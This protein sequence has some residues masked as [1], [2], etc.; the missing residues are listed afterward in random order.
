MNMEARVLPA[1]SVVKLMPE[2]ILLPMCQGL[3]WIPGAECYR[4]WPGPLSPR[5]Y[6]PLKGRQSF[7]GKGL[8][9]Q[10]LKKWRNGTSKREKNTVRWRPEHATAQGNQDLQIQ[11]QEAP[12]VEMQQMR[13]GREERNERR[14]RPDQESRHLGHHTHR[15]LLLAGKKDNGTLEMIIYD[16]SSLWNGCSDNRSDKMI[17]VNHWGH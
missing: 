13:E 4:G 8:V 7:R 1:R 15:P 11:I 17:A 2:H 16:Q 10:S 5:G 6:A 14:P 3:F 9:M 12:V